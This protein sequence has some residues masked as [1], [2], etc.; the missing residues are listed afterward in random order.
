MSELVRDGE[1]GE[2]FV[3]GDAADLRARLERLVREPERLDRYRSACPATKTMTQ[4][5]DEIE[6]LY[7]DA[8]TERRQQAALQGNA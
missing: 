4:N 8:I 3:A 6:A 2:L 5:I 7:R 1:N